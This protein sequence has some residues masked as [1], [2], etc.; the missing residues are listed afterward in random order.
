[1]TDSGLSAGQRAP[2]FIGPAA[3]GRVASFYELW[4]GRPLLLAVCRN[5]DR[6][7]AGPAWA[8]VR[9]EIGGAV[10][11]VVLREGPAIASPTG[12]VIA[13]RGGLAEAF[14]GGWPET[15]E[16]MLFDATL[17]LLDRMPLAEVGAARL[18]R[19]LA[20]APAATD[21]P[22]LRVPRLLGPGLCEALIAAHAAD[23]APSPVIGLVGGRPAAA[24]D[25][26]RKARLDHLLADGPLARQVVQRLQLVLLPEVEKAFAFRAQRYEPF[27]VA[28][29]D[30]GAGH[31]RPH[32]DNTSPEVALRRFA[33]TVGLQD[34]GY[35]GGGLR[36]PEFGPRLYHPAAGEALV[37]S[38]AHL[39]EL[40]D[41]AEGARHVL[42]TFLL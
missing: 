22:L 15:A 37:F 3:D 38:C 42:L 29:Y 40:T 23:H 12:P 28:R 8:Q 30:A 10:G 13:D 21:A 25:P 33:V 2:D 26:G 24:L 11:L 36:F 16:V 1:M 9:E 39:H 6:V 19:A 17:R 4:C 27:K 31:F 20:A 18:R 34:G 5:P 32:R 7:A 41:V 35:G 14:C